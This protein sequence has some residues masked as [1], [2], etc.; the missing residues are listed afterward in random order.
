[1]GISI[2]RSVT[3]PTINNE[4]IKLNSRGL[5]GTT[6]DQMTYRYILTGGGLEFRKQK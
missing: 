3:T 1:M 6:D 5:I 2:E 4:A